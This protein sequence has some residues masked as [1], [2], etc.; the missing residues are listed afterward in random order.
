MEEVLKKKAKEILQGNTRFHCY[1]HALEVLENVK[2]LISGQEKRHDTDVLFAA[3]LFH[4]AS[5]YSDNE[6]E[7]KDG[8]K[9]TKSIL[10]KM[11]EFPKDKIEDVGRLIE[12]INRPAKPEDE[13]IINTADE[14]AAFSDLGLIRSFMIAGAKGTKVPDAIKWDLEYLDKRFK[15]LKIN[16]AKKLIEYGYKKKNKILT[17]LLLSYKK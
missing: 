17:K 15:K 10:S 2:L 8:A 3:A 16:S 6:R 13:I 11:K 4:D 7:G 9:I 14:M 1:G 5:N 12:S